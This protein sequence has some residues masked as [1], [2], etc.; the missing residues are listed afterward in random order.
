MKKEKEYY[1]LDV[2]P[3][4]GSGEV[5]IAVYQDA[6][7]EDAEYYGI[8]TVCGLQTGRK[9]NR[10]EVVGLWNKRSPRKFPQAVWKDAEVPMQKLRLFGCSACGVKKLQKTSYCP[11][12]G[13]KMEMRY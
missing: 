3:C 4:C 11:E 1:E 2:C 5:K 8:C 13:E 10:G 9:K 12:C 6:H 7:T